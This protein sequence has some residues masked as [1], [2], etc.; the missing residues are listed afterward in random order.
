VPDRLRGGTSDR[1]EDEAAE[2]QQ[3]SGRHG[4]RKALVQQPDPQ[5][6]RNERFSEGEGR[7]GRGG[8]VAQAGDVEPVRQ[9]D[10]DRAE[11]QDQAKRARPGQFWQLRQRPGG[12]GGA[13]EH[14]G[15]RHRGQHVHVGLD[16]VLG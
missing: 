8:K 13:A 1:N 7:G 2:Q 12:Q 9:G 14:Q 3:R 6:G 16:Q 5:R 10:G 11:P 15:D 4:Q